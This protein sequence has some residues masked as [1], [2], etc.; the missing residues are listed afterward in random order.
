MS[1][2]SHTH[3][4]ERLSDLTDAQ[5][6]VRLWL[7]MK[8][9]RRLLFTALLLYIPIVGAMMLEP[10]LIGEAIDEYLKGAGSSAERLAG[11]THYGLIGVAAALGGAAAMGLQQL[12]LQRLGLN[13]LRD[14]R[15][16]TFDKAMRLDLKVYDHEP[17]G[18]VMARMTNDIDSLTEVFAFGAV[19]MVADLILLAAVT[20]WLFVLDVKLALFAMLVVPP[21]LVI[22]RVFQRYAHNTYGS[23]RRR[24]SALNAY[25]QETLNGLS[26]VQLFAAEDYLESRYDAQNQGYRD[27]AFDTIRYDVTLFAVIESIGTVSTALIIWYGAGALDQGLVT[28][29]LLIAFSEYMRRFFTPLRDLGSKYAMLQAGFASA[30]RVFGLLDTPI[31][32]GDNESPVVLDQPIES[33]RLE[34]VHFHYLPDEPVL[35]DVDF[36]LRQGE[37]VAIVGRTGSGKSTLLALLLRFRSPQS[38]RV[39]V[40]GIDLAQLEA[41]SLRKRLGVVQQ[42]S[43]LFA[44]SLEQNITMDAL[45]VDAERLALAFQASHLDQVKERLAARRDADQADGDAPEIL[46]GGSNLSAGERQLVAMARALYRNPE[47][48]LLDEA[49]ANIDQETERL[50]TR[51]TEAVLEGRTALVI[52]HRLSTVEKSDRIIVLDQG[53]VLESGSPAELLAQGGAYA[54]LVAHHRALTTP[55]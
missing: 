21:L 12:C 27:A 22:M 52:A 5:L 35:S 6:I 1:Q 39:T 25:L 20:I 8:P 31:E 55:S 34:G 11:V 18:R 37:R 38:G 4:D 16:T 30:D 29:G 50:L 36:T 40:N 24:S 26:T 15:R 54:E 42:D 9:H 33:M 17:V 2:P 32:L 45:D 19:G 48:L 44:G 41:S 47:V 49:T 14:L 7:Y 13:T 53:R 10:W 23:L 46:E 3:R 51:T 28:L 43:F